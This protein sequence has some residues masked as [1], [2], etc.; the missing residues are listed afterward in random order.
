MMKDKIYENLSKGFTQDEAEL[1]A[2]NTLLG[3]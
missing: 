1:E 2:F 3:A